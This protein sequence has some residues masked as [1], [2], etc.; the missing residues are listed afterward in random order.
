MGMTKRARASQSW[1]RYQRA[2]HHQP[3]SCAHVVRSGRRAIRRKTCAEAGPC[4]GPIHHL[5][6]SSRTCVSLPAFSTAATAASTCGA[7]RRLISATSASDSTWICTPC[8]ISSSRALFLRLPLFAEFFGR[9]RTRGLVDQ[10]FGVGRQRV[11]LCRV[12]DERKGRRAQPGSGRM[13][14]NCAEVQRQ[15]GLVRESCALNDALRDS[16]LGLGW[17]DQQRHCAERVE[18][19]SILHARV[20]DLDALEVVQLGDRHARIDEDGHRRSHEQDVQSFMLIGQIGCS[21]LGQASPRYRG[22]GTSSAGEDARGRRR[23]ERRVSRRAAR[24]PY[25]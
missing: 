24:T 4:A 10:G 18:Q 8:L 23:A 11:V 7:T 21:E 13:F 5:V 19:I 20:A 25:P 17:R 6:Y 2:R 3:L 12:H 16:V 15:R 9:S 1:L 22:A 14:G